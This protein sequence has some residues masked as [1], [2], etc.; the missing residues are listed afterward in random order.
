MRR[1]LLSGCLFAMMS[2]AAPPALAHD[3]R[4]DRFDTYIG[5]TSLNDVLA[6]CNT[7][8]GHRDFCVRGLGDYVVTDHIDGAL[9]HDLI[10]DAVC[11]PRDPAGRPDTAE[12]GRQVLDRL[13]HFPG[14]RSTW[15]VTLLSYQIIPALYPCLK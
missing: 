11:W 4:F 5:T 14:N 15:V 10:G 9:N 12:M 1:A 7:D 13:E 2:V 3:K 8:A 6:F